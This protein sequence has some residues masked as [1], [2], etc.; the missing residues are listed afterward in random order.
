ML[1]ETKMNPFLLFLFLLFFN[2]DRLS[3][4]SSADYCVLEAVKIDKQ[5]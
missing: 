1:V 5:N 2:T 3:D 4:S